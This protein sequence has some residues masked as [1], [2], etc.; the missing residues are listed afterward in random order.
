MDGWRTRYL[1]PLF[2]FSYLVSY[3]VS[4]FCIY[5]TG[6]LRLIFSGWSLLFDASEDWDDGLVYERERERERERAR[7][8]ERVESHYVLSVCKG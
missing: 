3:L 5:Q 7:E 4:F 1:S 2:L 8:R 6:L